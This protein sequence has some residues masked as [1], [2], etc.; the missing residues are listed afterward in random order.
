MKPE[1]LSI[2]SGFTGDKVT[3]ATVVP[4]YQT[5][6]YNHRTA[7]QLADI[8]EGKAGGYIY[9]RIANP[10]TT[11]LENRL[12]ELEEGIGCIATSSGMA[13]ISAVATGLLE[14]GTEILSAR[15]IFGGTAS[16][17]KNTLARFGIKTRFVDAGK[18]KEFAENINDNTRFV[19]VETIG[20]PGMT[21]PDI[22]AVAEIAHNANIPLVV[23][24]TVTTPAVFKPG[25]F[26]ADIVIHSTSKFINGHGTAI[27][28]AIIDTGNYDWSSGVF[29]DIKRLAG[30]VRQLAF[31]S[32]LRN[33]IY[34]DLGG[35]PAPMNSFLMLQGL[36]TLFFRMTKHCRNAARL[37]QFLHKHPKIR[38]INYPGLKT[39]RFFERTMRLFEGGGG[40]L[41]TFGLG[42]KQ[43]AFRFIDSLKLAKNAANLGDAKTLIIHPGSTIFQEFSAEQKQEMGI[44]E[45]MVRVSVGIEDFEDIKE[46]F[47]QAISKTFEV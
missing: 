45:D 24:N 44:T 20:N 19:F 8:F 31:L 13:A 36:E 11:A 22:P 23:D 17:F 21:V 41:L 35:C 10:T 3:N 26:G 29:E 1:T 47:N 15:D 30:T 42:D 38:R 37:A 33:T 25:R 7:E 16:L 46:D 34:R 5:V 2:H 40:A 6:S 9:S 18:T 27:G 12:A 4:I 43:K 14:T 39:S 32:Y 28:G